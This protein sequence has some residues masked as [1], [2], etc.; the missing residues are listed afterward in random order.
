MLELNEIINQNSKEHNSA[1]HGIFSKTGHIFG[2]K[3]S[4]N[5]YKKTTSSI[6]SFHLTTDCDAL[7]LDID[8]RKFPNSWETEQD[9]TE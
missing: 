8:N 3:A 9:S 6:L 5:R 4:R 7:N 2:H 1:P